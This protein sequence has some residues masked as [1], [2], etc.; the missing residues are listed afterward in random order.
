MPPPILPRLALTPLHAPVRL[1]HRV[2]H[3]LALGL[4]VPRRAGAAREAVRAMLEVVVVG[5]EELGLGGE[6][7][8]VAAEIGGALLER[9]RVGAGAFAE[10]VGV[11][12]GADL[13]GV[14]CDGKKGR[15]MRVHAG[16]V[17][18]EE[19]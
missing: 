3:H 12:V 14:V 19:G 13:D 1:L 16:D 15:G 8:G 9:R 4:A 5:G 11:R 2:P 6:A 17:A 7:R 10:G 18:G